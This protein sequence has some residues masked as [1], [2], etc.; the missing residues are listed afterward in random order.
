M[1]QD[2][3]EPMGTN[4]ARVDALRQRYYSDYRQFS[5]IDRA[6]ELA[7]SDSNVLEIGCNDGRNSPDLKG[8]VAFYAGV[9]PDPRVLRASKF[10]DAR[11]GHVEQLPWPDETFDIVFHHMVA[12]HL[13]DPTTAIREIARVLK[14][15]GTL[16]F[17]TTN[18]WHY[19]MIVASLTPHWFHQWYLAR[20]ARRTAADV[21]PTFYRSN[22][23]RPIMAALRAAGLEGQLTFVSRPP[24]YLS[25][26]PALFRLGILYERTVERAMPML[27]ARIMV[28]ARRICPA[29]GVGPIHS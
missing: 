27:R 2:E 6:V 15:G 21:H 3:T 4:R 11:L 7:R 25:L 22:S 20:V 29:P 19:A 13:P 8:R 24:N 12:E 23:R 16:V 26:H 14:P 5:A 18:R 1:L 28:E 10:D 17:E 9:D